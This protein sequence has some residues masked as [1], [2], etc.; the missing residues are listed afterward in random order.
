MKN[1]LLTILIAFPLILFASGSEEIDK[2][3]ALAPAMMLSQTD[4]VGAYIRQTCDKIARVHA[5]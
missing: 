3:I 1:E 2:A 5:R 4:D